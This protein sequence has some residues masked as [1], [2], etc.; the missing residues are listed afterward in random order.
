MYGMNSAAV[1]FDGIHKYIRITDIDENARMFRPNPLTSPNGIIDIRYKLSEGDIVFARTGASVGK[2]YIYNRN[3]GEL[4]F[5]GFLIK[6]SVISGD[7]YFIFCQTLQESYNK[8]VQVMSTRSGQ[9]WINAEEYKKLP[10]STP[11]IK[12]QQKISSFLRSI[13]RRIEKLEQKKQ[14]L[15]EYK[16]WVMQKIFS[17][18][19]KFKDKDNKAFPKWKRRKLW[20]VANFLKW[21]WISKNEISEDW[22]IPCI[23]YWEL[24]TCYKESINIVVS[25]TNLTKAD[26]VLSEA[27]DVIIPSSGETHIDIAKASC[28]CK[29]WIALGGDINIIRT[30]HN[31]LFLAYY[32]NNVKRKEIAQL[33]QGSSVVHLYAKELRQLL[34][35][36]PVFDEQL[37]I[38]HFLLW[39]DNEIENIQR[40]IDG[41]R[42]FKK[43]L[44]QQMF[45]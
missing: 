44:L 31:G 20:E 13:D 16:K 17:G 26:L 6:F 7:P 27:N 18:E 23:R 1:G 28:V 22:K 40:I 42:Q 33:A 34:L 10:I 4:Y 41:N 25:K 21:K 12:E 45:V 43:W 14:L 24:Y 5:A 39:I 19:I 30:E 32:L 38:A 36:L 11:S 29:S 9:P 15:E 3:D 2:S 37:K 35:D 8:W